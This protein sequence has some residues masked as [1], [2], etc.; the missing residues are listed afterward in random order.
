MSSAISWRPLPRLPADRG[1]AVPGVHNVPMFLAGCTTDHAGAD[2]PRGV[3][4][5][6]AA[7]ETASHPRLATGQQQFL[8]KYTDP[9]GQ[10]GTMYKVLTGPGLSLHA[11][12]RCLWIGS[13]WGG[14]AGHP[15]LKGEQK[16]TLS[17]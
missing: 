12:Y 10:D 8:D 5:G 7:G 14:R 4:P 3:G 6:L 13:A 17:F 16:K 1:A 9:A 11:G 2:S 15:L